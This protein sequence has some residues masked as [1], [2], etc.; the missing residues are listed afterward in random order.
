MFGVGLGVQK[1]ARLVGPRLGVIMPAML[2]VMGIFTIANRGLAFGPAD[3]AGGGAADAAAA[4]G[5]ESPDAC[6]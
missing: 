2:V 3:L 5:T 6:H 1:L 4:P